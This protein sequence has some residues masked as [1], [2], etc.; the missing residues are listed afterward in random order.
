M[1]ATLICLTIAISTVMTLAPESETTAMASRIA[2][3]AMMPSMIRIS[4]AS[5]QRCAAS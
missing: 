1:V 4:T 2:G 3:I 5:S